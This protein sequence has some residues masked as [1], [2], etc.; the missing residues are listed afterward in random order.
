MTTTAP[1]VTSAEISRESMIDRFFRA[2]GWKLVPSDD[3]PSRPAIAH[4]AKTTTANRY[5][6]R[7]AAIV[8]DPRKTCGSVPSRSVS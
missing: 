6:V 4:V 1:P 7:S 5:L 3:R 8:C 2:L